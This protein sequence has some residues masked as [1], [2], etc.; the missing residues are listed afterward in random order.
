MT[1]LSCLLQL[2]LYFRETAFPL[3]VKETL[4]RGRS[5]CR[6]QGPA[7]APAPRPPFLSLFPSACSPAAARL[8]VPRPGRDEA[9]PLGDAVREAVGGRGRPAPGRWWLEVGGLAGGADT[10]L[11]R[12]AKRRGWEGPG[13]LWQRGRKTG[14]CR[15][16]PAPV[17]AT[18]AV[19][20]VPRGTT[21]ATVALGGWGWPGGGGL[22]GTQLLPEAMVPPLSVGC[23]SCFTLLWV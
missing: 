7:V 2:F 22:C 12:V 17:P 5:R 9:A 23:L 1:R 3:L 6:R 8:V 16:G 20:E 11:G 18:P 10:F 21:V 15:E 19:A 13:Q 4:E 14:S